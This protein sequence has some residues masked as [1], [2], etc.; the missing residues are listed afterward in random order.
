MVST[1]P[2]L[3]AFLDKPFEPSP[4]SPASRLF[5]NEFYIDPARVPEFAMLPASVRS[6]RFP[7]KASRYVDYKVA[8]REKRKV[9]DTLA[10]SFFSKG[11]ERR[12]QEFQ[13]FL[14][15]N[16]ES[17]AYAQFRARIETSGKGGHDR[18]A[19]EFHLYVQWIVRQQLHELA[20]TMSAGGSFLYLDL[21]LGLHRDAYDVWRFP[22]LFVKG[23]SGGAPPDP[24]FT[25]GQDWAFQPLHP[26]AMREDGY[27]YA[28]AVLR[29]HLRYAKLLR[30]DH[31]MGLHR[32]FWIPD[33]S[34]GDRGVYVRY[35]AEEMYAILS[36][37]SHRAQAGIVGENLGVVPPEVNRAMD[38]HNIRQLYVAQYETAV[39]SGTTALRKPPRG[40]VASLNTH[41]LFPFQAF[42]EGSDIET[43]LRLKLL[44]SE[45]A[46][47]ERKQRARISRALRR[48]AGKD[49]LKGCL[50]FLAKSPASVVLV[51]LEDLWKETAAQN[52]PSTTT[53]HPNW[54]RAMRYSMQ[55]LKSEIGQIQLTRK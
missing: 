6:Q 43:R 13:R 35:P 54:K 17:T 50:D 49:V 26:Q 36:L 22:D 11:S 33:G 27:R 39:E 53:Q 14:E 21:P 15:E 1:L 25:T 37:E 7:D 30:I 2:L 3:A 47:V 55:R 5:W 45:D 24:V 44:K 40:S 29:N 10:Q 4:Y 38:R 20:L 31:V 23:V 16:P 41:D 12:R 28:I 18:R 46:T 48:F 9:L 32:L 34:K 8:T 51:N 19:E 52:V 42:L